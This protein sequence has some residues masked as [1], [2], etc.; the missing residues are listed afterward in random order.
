MRAGAVF[1]LPVFFSGKDRFGAMRGRAGRT[2][3]GCSLFAGPLLVV[4]V[5]AVEAAEEGEVPVE[6]VWGCEEDEDDGNVVGV[7]PLMRE[8]PDCKARRRVRRM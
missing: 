1:S 3:R 5:M 7:G 4:V 2:L 6:A 8:D